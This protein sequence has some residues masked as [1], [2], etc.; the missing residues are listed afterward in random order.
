MV[1]IFD[2]FLDQ[3]RGGPQR[4]ASSLGGSHTATDNTRVG[5]KARKIVIELGEMWTRR[6]SERS[7]SE[8]F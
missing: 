8:S 5:A 2:V 7:Q 6:K 1:L 3:F 4:T